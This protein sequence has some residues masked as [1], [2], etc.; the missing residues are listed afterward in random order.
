MRCLHD[1]ARRQAGSARLARIRLLAR[2]SGAKSRDILRCDSFSH[3]ACGREF[4]YWIERFGYGGRCWSA[5]ENIAY[6]SPGAYA[7]PRIIMRGWLHSTG[8]RQNILRR[9]FTDF[10]VGLAIGELD[11]LPDTH[12][13]TAHFGYRC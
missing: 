2:S 4:T 12:V 11:G 13:W 9:I 6:G 10:N 8:H 3:E 7:T 1:F 5:G